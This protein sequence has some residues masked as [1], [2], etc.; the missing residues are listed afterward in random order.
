MRTLALLLPF[1]LGAA[2]A[3]ATD[4]VRFQD[5]TLAVDLP[6]D[7]TMS[8]QGGEYQLT[9]ESQDTASLL[10]LLAEPGGTLSE[11]LAEI[12][13][14]FL[15]TDL[16]EPELAESRKVDGVP[17]LHRR[18]R[19]TMGGAEAEAGTSIL[20]HQYSFERAGIPVLLQVETAPGRSAHEKLFRGVLETLEI[21]AAPPRFRFED[22]VGEPSP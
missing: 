7:W 4:P 17:V 5:E 3:A 16:I 9:S 12:E 6:A 20:L 1:A 13:Q 10:L 21:R 14:Q 18:Y 2:P 19:L 8:G 22:S 15:E 11:R